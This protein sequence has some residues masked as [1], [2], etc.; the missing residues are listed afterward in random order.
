MNLASNVVWEA[1][2]RDIGELHDPQIPAYV[3]LNSRLSWKVC[4]SLELA[5]G[6]MNLLQKRH[7][8]YEP[9]G[10]TF[11]DEVERSFYVET[12]WRF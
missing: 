12:K 8:E 6:G 5:V 7:L 4:E 9:D 2:L 10:A 1:D 11:G 3:E